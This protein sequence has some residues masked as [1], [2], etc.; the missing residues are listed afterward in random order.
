MQ[1]H[2]QDS[3]DGGRAASLTTN[4][5]S[6]NVGR[7]RVKPG[8]DELALAVALLAFMEGKYLRRD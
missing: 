4:P 3:Y 5:T 6:E 2:K 1:D 8:D 7:D